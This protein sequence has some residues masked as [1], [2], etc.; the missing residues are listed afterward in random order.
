MSTNDL[1]SNNIRPIKAFV[2]I[3]RQNIKEGI[4]VAEIGAFD[5]TTTKEY[6]GLVSEYNSVSQVI[7]WLC[8]NICVG[9]IHGYNRSE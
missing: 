7:D 6:V 4:I 1:G 5:G 2:D 8:G 9:G 3:V